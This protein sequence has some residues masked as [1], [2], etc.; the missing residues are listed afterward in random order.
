V[1]WEQKRRRRA[2]TG[3]PRAP[4]KGRGE[5]EPSL[6]EMTRR[7]LRTIDRCRV[8]GSLQDTSNQKLKARNMAS[9]RRKSAF[10]QTEIQRTWL[11]NDSFVSIP[12]E[13]KR[14]LAN[15]VLD[16]LLIEP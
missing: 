3:I 4:A 11:C 2:T 7:R 9:E 5:N 13:E 8:S 14:S 10:F 6:V 16:D 15:T 12:K 1:R